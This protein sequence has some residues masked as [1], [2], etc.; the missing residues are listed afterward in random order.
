MKFQSTVIILGVGYQVGQSFVTC[1]GCIKFTCFSRPCEDRDGSLFK[2]FWMLESIGSEC[3]QSCDGTIVPPNKLVMT[4]QLGGRCKVREVAV[5]KTATEGIK[6]RLCN[7]F[8]NYWF[9]DQLRVLLKFL[10]KVTTAV[11]M[12]L[13]GHSLVIAGWSLRLALGGHVVL[14]PLQVGTQRWCSQGNSQRN[15]IFWFRRQILTIVITDFHSLFS[16]STLI[17]FDPLRVN[18]QS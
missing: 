18:S 9:Q 8:V 4:A 16:L 13:V 17:A 1:S 7:I 12:N 6:A 14:V 10:M 3:C 5:C 2:M 15:I 11:L